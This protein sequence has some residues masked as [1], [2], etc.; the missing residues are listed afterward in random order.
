[1]TQNQHDKK[2]TQRPDQQQAFGDVWI[3]GEGNT[4]NAIQ[5]RDIQ[6]HL[7]TAESTPDVDIDWHV[8]SRKLLDEQFSLMADSQRSRYQARGMFVPLGLM[9]RKKG[10]VQKTDIPSKDNPSQ[11]GGLA[12]KPKTATVEVSERFAHESFLKKISGQGQGSK[13]KRIAVVGEP[14]AGK[15]TFL[16]QTAQWL[17]DNISR[18]VVIW[19]SLANLDNKLKTHIEQDWLT[20]VLENNDRTQVSAQAKQNFF[21]QL[22]EGRVWLLLDGLD[23]M[24][25]V[26]PVEVEIRNQLTHIGKLQYANIVLTCRPNVWNDRLGGFDTYRTLEL[27]TSEQVKEFIDRWFQW[28]NA[29]EEQSRRLFEELQKPNNRR[30]L[31]LVKNPLRLSLLCLDW[32]L[33]EGKLPNTQADLYQNFVDS[34]YQRE[35]NGLSKAEKDALNAAL[36][37]LALASIDNQDKQKN[38]F[39]LRRD[40]IDEHWKDESLLKQAL[41]LGWLN[42]IG[43]DESNP[44][45]AVYTFYHATFQEYFAALAIEDWDFFLPRKHRRRPVK[46]EGRKNEY[47][48]YRMFEPQWKQV[49]LLWLGR[50]D[51]DTRTKDEF[52]RALITFKDDAGEIYSDRALLIASEGLAEFTECNPDYKSKIITKIVIQWSCNHS[53]LE[54]SFTEGEVSLVRIFKGVMQNSHPRSSVRKDLAATAL[55]DKDYSWMILELLQ[56]LQDNSLNRQDRITIAES[57]SRI[58][59]DERVVQALLKLLKDDSFN[60]MSYN[61]VVRILGG[62]NNNEDVIQALLERLQDTSQNGYYDRLA[63]IESLGRIGSN[64][65]RVIQALLECLQDTSQDRYNRIAAIESLGR[66]GS[67]D[68]RVIQALLECLQDDSQNSYDWVATIESLGK[69]DNNNR[70]AI[71]ALLQSLLNNLLNDSYRRAASESLGKI[72]S[73]D[74]GVIQALLQR[75]QDDS[76]SK[77]LYSAVVESLG[78]I[79]SNDERVIQ[80]L[81]QRL[82]DTSLESHDQIAV[83]RSLV[84]IGNNDESVI[85]VLLQHLNDKSYS[86]EGNRKAAAEILVKIGTLDERVIQALLQFIHDNP[87]AERETELQKFMTNLSRRLPY[88]EFYKALRS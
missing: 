57:I 6:V 56:W 37:K 5:G 9:E 47:V 42:Q 10:F 76:L 20:A 63:A 54:Q 74:E 39:R 1:M 48:P 25:A 46:V 75:L 24:R 49:F 81:L 58:G 28:K 11:D 8:E 70:R 79:G 41:A 43:V 3:Q 23:E 73:N 85:Q 38:G 53:S 64:D 12:E 77:N 52:I 17:L 59:D 62:I 84:E 36:S 40:F 21:E 35:Q 34:I 22:N 60:R 80:A 50:S 7:S 67:N 27:E 19:I 15:T 44:P 69:I 87:F 29:P 86:S 33:K 4:F 16:R 65:E 26:K 82:N 78:K 72:G 55:S 51:I 45:Q 68:E 66:I 83:A 13:R 88:T 18:S 61:P 30:I 2:E 32:H 14:G 31:D 71:Q